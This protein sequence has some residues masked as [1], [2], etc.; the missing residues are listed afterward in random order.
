M[1]T[2]KSLALT[3]LEDLKAIK[4]S[5]LD[6][7]H[8]TTVTDYMI[9]VTGN[10][11][12]HVRAMAE[13]LIQKAKEH[14]HQPLGVEG[15]VEAEWILVDLGDVVVHI[16]LSHTREFYSLEKLWGDM[17]AET[18]VTEAKAATA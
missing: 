13:K 3:T 15:E 18:E 12:R 1:T 5:V 17:E 2:L 4:P 6:V 7:R 9:I 11:N 8:L 10:S 14:H 16:M